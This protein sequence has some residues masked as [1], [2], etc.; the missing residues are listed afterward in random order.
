[1]GIEYRWYG[2]RDGFNIELTTFGSEREETRVVICTFINRVRITV[3]YLK[4]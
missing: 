3:I 1:M 4:T 2:D